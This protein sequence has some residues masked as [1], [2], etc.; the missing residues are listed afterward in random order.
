M[1]RASKRMM[2]LSKLRKLQSIYKKEYV[3][4]VMEEHDEIG[5]KLEKGQKYAAKT[6]VR[7]EDMIMDLE[8]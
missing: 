3:N 7:L 8:C 4:I 1:R 5:E 6:Y 2:P